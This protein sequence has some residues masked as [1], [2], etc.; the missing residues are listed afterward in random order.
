MLLLY[1][2]WVSSY[3]ISLFLKRHDSPVTDYKQIS[4]QN[5]LL[6]FSS[7]EILIYSS[8]PTSN[9][10]PSVNLLDRINCYLSVRL[11]F[12]SSCVM[13]LP[14]SV[15]ALSCELNQSRLPY[16][17]LYPSLGPGTRFK[18]YIVKR[19]LINEQHFI[20]YKVITNIYLILTLQQSYEV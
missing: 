13:I 8:K 15:T 18:I 10:F 19:G 12:C 20:V 9:I 16:S 7:G 6:S 1:A 14:L 3:H 11:K 2:F 5:A 17:F 4:D